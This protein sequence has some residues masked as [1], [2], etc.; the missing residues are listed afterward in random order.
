MRAD[1]HLHN[2]KNL[3]IEASYYGHKLTEPIY[4]SWSHSSFDDID[5]LLNERKVP[6]DSVTYMHLPYAKLFMTP[7][8]SVEL[9]IKSDRTKDVGY[10]PTCLDGLKNPLKPRSRVVVSTKKL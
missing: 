10:I 2:A 3:I 9:T 6:P 8:K 1:R 5:L 7:C 4:D